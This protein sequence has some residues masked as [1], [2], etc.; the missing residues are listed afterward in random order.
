MALS[1][2]SFCLIKA[3]FEDGG[4]LN[5]LLTE[6]EEKSGSTSAFSTQAS[7]RDSNRVFFDLYLFIDVVHFSVCL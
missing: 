6:K 1:F 2:L 5:I 3:S 7:G 4:G